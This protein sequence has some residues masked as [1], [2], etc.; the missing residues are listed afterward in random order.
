MNDSQDLALPLITTAAEGGPHHDDSYVA[1]WE[2][3]ELHAVLREL[4]PSEVERQV[5]TESLPMVD[6]LAMQYGYTMRAARDLDGWTWIC[7]QRAKATQPQMLTQAT[8]A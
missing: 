4:R 6:L 1:G 8:P 3:G 7:L 2:M 5:R